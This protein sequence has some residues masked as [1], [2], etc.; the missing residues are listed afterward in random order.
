MIGEDASFQISQ[1]SKHAL[2][3]YL[4]SEIAYNNIRLQLSQECPVLY[5]GYVHC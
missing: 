5:V 3:P 4:D 1:Q 2:R